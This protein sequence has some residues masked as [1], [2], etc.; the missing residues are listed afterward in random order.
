[1]L[2]EQYE[3]GRRSFKTWFLSFQAA[4][5]AAGIVDDGPEKSRPSHVTLKASSN[6]LNLNQ[7]WR[8][9]VYL[10]RNRRR[11]SLKLSRVTFP[12]RS[13]Y[14][15]WPKMFLWRRK[16][17]VTFALSETTDYQ[18]D[19]AE[20]KHFFW[21][22]ETNFAKF[23]VQKMADT[24]SRSVNSGGSGTSSNVPL[25]STGNPQLDTL[26]HLMAGG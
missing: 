6:L 18:I 17:A 7:C 25:N 23:L 4:A 10:E 15:L 11:S 19:A 9:S 24:K 13:F 20:E 5:A 3:G 22:G 12:S 16:N 8:R 2:S 14:G 21:G 1:M 26:I